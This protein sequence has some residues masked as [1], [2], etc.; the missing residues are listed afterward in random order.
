MKG[1]ESEE[2]DL[3]TREQISES[4]VQGAWFFGFSDAAVEPPLIT[5]LTS[6]PSSTFR[7]AARL[8]NA[9]SFQLSAMI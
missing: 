3:A 9:S 8:A 7:S 4:L 1:S 2:P 6:S 5:D